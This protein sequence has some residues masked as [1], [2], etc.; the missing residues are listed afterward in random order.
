V[1]EDIAKVRLSHRRASYVELTGF[2]KFLIAVTTYRATV[3]GYKL[4]KAIVRKAKEEKMSCQFV[5]VTVP[6]PNC[7]IT[8]R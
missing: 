3:E 7:W 4:K 6:Y 5:T 2:S 1:L 8:A